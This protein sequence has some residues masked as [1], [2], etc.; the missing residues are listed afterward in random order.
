VPAVRTAPLGLLLILALAACGS[1]DGSS[2]GT[3]LEVRGTVTAGTSLVPPD[4]NDPTP[5]IPDPSD[6]QEVDISGTVTCGE[7]PTGT[8]IFAA[9]APQVCADLVARQGVFEQIS[10]NDDE[11]CA[12]VYGGPQEATVTGSIDGQSVDVSV[13]RANA[14]GIADWEALE[15]LLGPPER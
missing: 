15:W 6:A 4:P 9:T 7:V 5:P 3:E 14:C 13:D 8:G 11:V 10:S 12:E 2:S 1:S